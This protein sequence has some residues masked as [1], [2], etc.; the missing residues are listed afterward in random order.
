M[1]HLE[2]KWMISLDMADIAGL[3]PISEMRHYYIFVSAELQSLVVK[4]KNVKT[5]YKEYNAR[6]KYI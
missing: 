1:Y 2:N 6:L 5:M 4:I 3:H